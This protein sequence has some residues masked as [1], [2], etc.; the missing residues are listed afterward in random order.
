MS[1]TAKTP[2]PD[3]P[4]PAPPPAPPPPPPPS[5]SF[6]LSSFE[7]PGRRMRGGGIGGFVVSSAAAVVAVV[8][9]D[10]PEPSAED[11]LV[12]GSLV[13]IVGLSGGVLNS[14]APAEAL[15]LTE[16]NFMSSVSEEKRNASSFRAHDNEY[17]AL[18]D[19][20]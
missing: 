16:K 8:A 6:S 19:F 5:A 3:V 7:F 10:S 14:A 11:E 12:L 4:P 17:M 9:D 20:L 2:P 13:F 18:L 15:D 1:D